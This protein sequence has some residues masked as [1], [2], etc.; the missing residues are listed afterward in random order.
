[1]DTFVDSSWYFIRFTNPSYH[2]PT[3]PE[4]I[5]YWMNRINEEMIDLNSLKNASKQELHGLADCYQL[6]RQHLVESKVVDFSSVQ[7]ETL[8]LFRLHPTVLEELQSQV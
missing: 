1:M 5:K 4:D 2:K 7:A 6:Y 8:R 3:N